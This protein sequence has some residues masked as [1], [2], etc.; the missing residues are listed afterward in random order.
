MKLTWQDVEDIAGDLVTQYPGIDPLGV[1]LEKLQS[2]V[3]GLP[4][5]SD[6]P[7][8]ATKRV[9]EAIQEAWYDKNEE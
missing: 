2:M 7:Q 8:A 1:D 3:A 5:F 9:L 6:D 4:R